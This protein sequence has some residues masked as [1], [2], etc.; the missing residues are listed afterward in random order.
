MRALSPI[1]P[2]RLF[3]G[4]IMK[5]MPLARLAGKIFLTAGGVGVALLALV[6]TP[7]LEDGVSRWALGR[8]QQAGIAARVD[9]LRYNLL[10][11]HVRVEGV[12]LAANATPRQPFL[13]AHAIDVVLPWSVITG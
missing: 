10:T 12:S 3:F 6:H 2:G 1:R 4:D 8:L 11:R 5:L 7:W 13:T 9:R